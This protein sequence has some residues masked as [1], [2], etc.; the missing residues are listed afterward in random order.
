MNSRHK[1]A[2]DE[3]ISDNKFI[4]QFDIELRRERQ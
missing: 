2:F 4:E 3:V 1:M